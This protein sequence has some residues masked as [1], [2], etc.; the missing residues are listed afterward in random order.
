MVSEG[1]WQSVI[2]AKMDGIGVYSK[3]VGA[4]L[5]EGGCLYGCK[6]R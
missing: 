4:D 3:R 1:L 5:W 2:R 6:D